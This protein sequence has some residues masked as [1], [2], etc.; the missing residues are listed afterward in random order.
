MR[1]QGLVFA[2]VASDDHVALAGFLEAALG[3]PAAAEDGFR[4]LTFPNG[5]VL[6]LVPRDWV[7]PPSD[8]NLGFLVDDLA[9]ATDE[10]AALRVEPDGP[11]QVGEGFRY[12]HFKAPDGRRFELLE[13]RD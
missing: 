7:P 2:G 12:R 3:V 11:L 5:S 4:S 6:A 13:R 10:L 1:V 9:A 8:T